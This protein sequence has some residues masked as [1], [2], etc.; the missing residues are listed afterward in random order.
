[1]Q[2]VMGAGPRPVRAAAGSGAVVSRGGAVGEV[3]FRLQWSGRGRQVEGRG[4]N[5]WAGL[6]FSESWGVVP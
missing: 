1:M 4:I 3:G 5:W 6:P 2:E